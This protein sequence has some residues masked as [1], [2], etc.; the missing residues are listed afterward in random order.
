MP[1]TAATTPTTTTIIRSPEDQPSVF[2][3]LPEWLMP[4]NDISEKLATV[5]RFPKNKEEIALMNKV[6]DDVFEMSLDYIA[7]GVSL[8]SILRNDPRN[9]DY[10]RFLRWIKKSP[11]R[12]KQYEEAQEIKAEIIVDGMQDLTDPNRLTFHGKAISNEERKL[13]FETAKWIAGAL[14]KKKY[15]SNKHIE[16]SSSDLTDDVLDKMSSSDLK[17]MIVE[18]LGVD[19]ETIDLDEL[20]GVD[21]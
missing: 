1:D 21:D 8:S 19:P 2:D 16:V 18:Q 12:K 7:A 20:E 9:I 4:S 3:T 15:G 6:Y 10:A 13:Q 5:P 14:N 17:R 11:I